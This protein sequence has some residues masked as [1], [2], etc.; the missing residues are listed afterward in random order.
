[1][2]S[3]L[4]FVKNHHQHIAKV[5]AVTDSKFLAIM[6]SIASHFISAQ[7]RHFDYNDKESA[8]NRLTNSNT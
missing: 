7:V 8:L 3:H 1:M 5:A 6:P 2:L 4:E